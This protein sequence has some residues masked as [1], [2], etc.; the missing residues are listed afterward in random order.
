MDLREIDVLGNAIGKHWYYAS[1]A[2]AMRSFLGDTPCNKILDVGAGSGFFS[3]QLLASTGAS[4]AW[5]VDTS[6]ECES[7][8]R[9]GGKVI[10]YLRSVDP[11]DAD[12]VLLMDV[13]E[14]VDVDARL[15][16][17]Y[18]DKVPRGSRFL[19]TVPAFQWLWSGHDD[20]LGH[21]RRYTL[22]QV[23]RLVRSTGLE[24]ENSSY[25]FGLVLPIAAVLRLLERLRRD[26]GEP[27]SQLRQHPGIIN[28]LLKLLC[29]LEMVF[30]RPNRLAGLTIFCVAHKR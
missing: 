1:K 3:Q 9:V 5:C 15:L 7:E 18:V 19:I 25:Y 21:K 20:F 10:R 2:G 27:K 28:R 8:T 6:Y 4:E 26:P 13:L 30:L 14:H 17:D 11:V 16:A 29:S 22:A 23:E 24:I 12:L